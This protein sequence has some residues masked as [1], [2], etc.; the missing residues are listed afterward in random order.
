MPKVWKQI[1]PIFMESPLEEV[2][3][4][5]LA[6]AV[7]F[8]DERALTTMRQILIDDKSTPRLRENALQALLLQR[9]AELVPTLQVLLKDPSLRSPALRGLAFFDDPKTPKLILDQYSTFNTDEKTDA[10]QTL[11]S[12]VSYAQA[13]LSRR[14]KEA[15]AAG[16][17]VELHG[18][19]DCER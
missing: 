1:F 14:R 9:P 11:A 8:G 15:N 12:R 10:V 6:L 4:R 2:R 7:Q 5:A 16:G 13:L 18:A 19:A 3:E 17:S